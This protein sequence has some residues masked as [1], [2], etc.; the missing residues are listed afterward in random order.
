MRVPPATIR[1]L[2]RDG[3]QESSSF[4]YGCHFAGILISFTTR[5]RSNCRQLRLNFH[6]VSSCSP[7]HPIR[8]S[9]SLK[10]HH[11]EAL[12]IALNPLTLEIRQNISSSIPFRR[13][14]GWRGKR[15]AQKRHRINWS[16]TNRF[17]LAC[18][19]TL[20]PE[21]VGLIVR[22]TLS[23]LSSTSLCKIDNAVNLGMDLQVTNTTRP[24]MFHIDIIQSI[25]KGLQLLKASDD[26]PKLTSDTSGI[27][28]IV[29]IP[30]C[31]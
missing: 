7:A 1:T 8:S 26:V 27:V 11:S 15:M 10:L 23:Q 17:C 4:L 18:R 9:C 31:M 12:T 25:R 2:Q 3:K 5:I 24:W 22:Y 21:V 13:T 20:I 19:P 6:A 16:S 28:R 30:D 29:Y 14:H